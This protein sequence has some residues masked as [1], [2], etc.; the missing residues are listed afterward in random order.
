MLD[1]QERDSIISVYPF[2][3][4]ITR[5]SVRDDVTA[6][7]IFFVKSYIYIGFICS[8]FGPSKEGKIVSFPGYFGSLATLRLVRT[9]SNST[10][11]E[12]ISAPSGFQFESTVFVSCS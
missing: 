7:D 5:G 6:I 1:L 8:C 11:E 4:T 10:G 2:H 9:R 12:A 3:Y